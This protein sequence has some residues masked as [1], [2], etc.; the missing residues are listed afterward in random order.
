MMI[1]SSDF[2]KDAMQYLSKKK[3]TNAARE[4]RNHLDPEVETLLHRKSDQ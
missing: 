3:L 4:K 1:D 2:V